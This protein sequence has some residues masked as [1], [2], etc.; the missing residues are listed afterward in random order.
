MEEPFT[1]IKTV[2]KLKNNKNI[3]I[4]KTTIILIAALLVSSIGLGQELTVFEENG[5]QG[6]KDNN[7]TI[8]SKAIYDFTF[9]EWNSTGLIAV[10]LKGKIGYIDRTGKVIISPK[11]ET[12]SYSLFSNDGLAMV[13]LNGKIGYINTKDEIIIPFKYDFASSFD[14]NGLACVNIGGKL[15]V[16]S[17]NDTISI[18]K[19][20]WGCINKKGE[21]VIPLKYDMKASPTGSG[22]YP[23]GFTN[24]LIAVGNGSKWGFMDVYGKLVI[25][26]KYDHVSF[27]GFRDGDL[28]CVGMKIESRM[29]LG[30]I[31]KMGNE[32]IPTIYE[33]TGAYEPD[34]FV[35][36]TKN[37][38]WIYFENNTA[39]VGLNNKWGMI[40]NQNNI[41][42]PFKYDNE[43]D[44]RGRD[45]ALVK[46]NDKFGWI[47]IKGK[48]VI[49]IIYDS[50]YDFYDET[51]TKVYLNNE[52][53]YIDNKGNRIEN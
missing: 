36:G 34:Y 37:I 52:S 41:I 21:E 43:F 48:E 23:M 17:E 14:K 20:G 44:F 4:M 50:A 3:E 26:F 30:M 42:V 45:I 46:F 1:L 31:D 49:P 39:C 53:F 5:K 2:L 51:K 22:Q 19:G 16:D 33:G 11:Y 24:G 15:T 29:K 27:A 28:A 10:C 47:D 8:I 25:P 32:V 40:D 13:S 18:L 9:G 7:G 12:K 38:K 6:L 35:S